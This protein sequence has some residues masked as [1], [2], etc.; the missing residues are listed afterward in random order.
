MDGILSYQYLE[1]LVKERKIYANEP[2]RRWQFQPNTID[3]RL[4]KVA[5]KVV[6]RFISST[7]KVQ[8][9]INSFLTC[10][11][12]LKKGAILEKDSIYIIPLKEKLDLTTEIYG[13][14]NPK[15]ST[16]RLD[17]FT[18]I[19]TDFN[20]RINIV[21]SGYSGNLY[22]EVSPMSFTIRVR[23]NDS[24][25][26][27]RLIYGNSMRLMKKDLKDYH[28]NIPLLYDA[29]GK[30][31]SINDGNLN[32]GIFIRIDLSHSNDKRIIGYKSKKNRS[33]IDIS[34]EYHYD[35]NQFWEGIY[36]NL[37]D[38]IILEPDSFYIFS[39]KERIVIPPDICGEMV[40]YNPDSGQSVEH[41]A[42]FFDT[43]FGFSNNKK[44]A[45]AVFELRPYH[46][47]FSVQDGQ[48]LFS[49][50]YNR[51]IQIP[52]KFYGKTLNSHYQYQD[53]NL[54]KHFKVN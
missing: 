5:Y 49:L 37:D 10:K 22:L 27:L 16:S 31:G 18:T 33:I 40:P 39:S 11:I 46:A 38:Q 25:I 21:Q 30:P 28:K 17:I 52:S 19:L 12:D 41:Y 24:L 9:K 45:K 2:I 47:P 3:L 44:G 54:S 8:D 7:K 36:S 48:V 26:Q 53:V 51:N 6:S 4:D 20:N 50:I 43:G 15:S 34:K 14:A 23:E 1:R 32:D 13:K 42:R 29:D 35:V